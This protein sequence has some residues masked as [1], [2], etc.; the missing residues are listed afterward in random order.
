MLS[1]VPQKLDVNLIFF[2]NLMFIELSNLFVNSAFSNFLGKFDVIKI[3]SN[4]DISKKWFKTNQG[5]NSKLYKISFE[6][7]L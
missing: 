4:F 7:F 2:K 6:N 3:F 5:N 1:N